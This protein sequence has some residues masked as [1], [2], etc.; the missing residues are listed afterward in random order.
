MEKLNEILSEIKRLYEILK[1][2]ADNICVKKRI[3]ELQSQYR[4]ISSIVNN[5][6]N[7]KLIKRQICRRKAKRKRQYRNRVGL[8]LDKI[9]NQQ[10]IEQK[11]EEIDR[12]IMLINDKIRNEKEVVFFLF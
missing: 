9:L 2:D 1:N 6:K 12:N 8:K 4:N 5:E 11:N 3:E 7:L 10:A